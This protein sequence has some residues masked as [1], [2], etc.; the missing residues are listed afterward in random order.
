MAR[1]EMRTICSLSSVG[2]SHG[3]SVKREGDLIDDAADEVRTMRDVLKANARKI[4]A[5]YAFEEDGWV[6]EQGRFEAFRALREGGG[7]ANY[8]GMKVISGEGV[9]EIVFGDDVPH[10]FCIN[11]ELVM[12]DQ[13][14][15]WLER[16]G[17]VG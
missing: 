16:G 7:A 9:G 2:V 17:F 13:C 6:L 8:E 5:F 3:E 4:W 11:H 10:D 15:V 12:A 14:T 1:D